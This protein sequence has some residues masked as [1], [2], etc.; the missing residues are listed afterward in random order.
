M[1]R[2]STAVIPIMVAAAFLAGVFA[3]RGCG[4]WSPSNEEQLA[5]DTFRAAF[6]AVRDRYVD[7]SQTDPS[8]LVHEAITGM[9]EGLGDTGHSRFLTAE[10]RRRE[11]E[12]LSGSYVGIGV[13]VAERDGHPVV[14][15]AFP[16]SPAARAGIRS[17]DRFLK[18]NGED[19]SRVSL[20]DLG[21]YLRGPAGSELRVT[22]L[23]QDDTT[24]E[25]VLRREAITMPAVTWA[26]LAESAIWHI[27]LSRFGENA[28]EE[29]D[30][31][32]AEAQAAGAAGLILDLRNNPGGLLNQAIGVASRFIEDGVVLQ[33]RDRDGDDRSLHV[34]D[35]VAAVDLPL[36]VLVN[37]G[38]ASSSE[39]VTAALLYHDRAQAVGATTFGTGTVLREFTLPDGSVLLL[40]IREWL[41]PAGEP[42]RGEGLTP[43]HTV[44]LPEGVRP[45]LPDQPDAPPEQPCDSPDVQLRTA[46]VLLGLTCPSG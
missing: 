31:A 3:G 17:G 32:L 22:V 39:V 14:V 24:A 46:A 25:L 23:H 38:S 15:S 8:E 29:L 4:A 20:T 18:I 40:G 11:E 28:T 45:V 13:E 44:P 7:E 10:Q 34:A 5:L 19:V 1:P 27:R 6:R 41:T 30:R 26:P 33:E 35:G 12:A 21:A 9:I 43:T 37:E 16:E 36:V 2:L 42:L